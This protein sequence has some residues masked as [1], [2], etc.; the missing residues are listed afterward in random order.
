MPPYDKTPSRA[1]NDDGPRGGGSKS[2]KHRGHR[3]DEAGAPARKDRWNSDA[4]AERRGDAPR[5][6]GGRPN[7]E[8]R[9]KTGNSRFAPR[10]HDARNGERGRDGGAPRFGRDGGREAARAGRDGRPS[11]PW[12]R[13][14]RPARDDRGGRDDRAPRS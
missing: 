3:P 10:D 8:P 5:T 1:R 13:S 6:G 9:E 11:R 12:E 7:W 14:D 4:R 2:P